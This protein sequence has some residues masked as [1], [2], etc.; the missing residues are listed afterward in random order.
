MTSFNPSKRLSE[1]AAALLSPY[2]KLENEHH[3]QTPAPSLSVGL[4]SGNV[5]L[6]NVEIRPEAIEQF[7]NSCDDDGGDGNNGSPKAAQIKWKLRR[8]RIDPSKSKYPGNLFWSDLPAPLPKGGAIQRE[9][10]T[11]QLA[12][13]GETENTTNRRA[14][15]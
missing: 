6:N 2:I 1:H 14:R 13:S 11:T 9:A 12:E 4:W 3:D 10:T 15:H 8:G 5:E 7:L